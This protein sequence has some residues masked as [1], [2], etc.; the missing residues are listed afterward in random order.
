MV[1]QYL[2]S[3][4]FGL[5]ILYNDEVRLVKNTIASTTDTIFCMEQKKNKSEKISALAA[6]SPA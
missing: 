4:S 1:L 5:S 2:P 3:L 6:V